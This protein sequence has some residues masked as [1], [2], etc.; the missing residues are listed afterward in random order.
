[1]ITLPTLEATRTISAF[2]LSGN[3][4]AGQTVALKFAVGKSDASLTVRVSPL[5]AG[6][7]AR[8]TAVMAKLVCG[9]N[10]I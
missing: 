9:S 10:A 1:V 3:S 8:A 2:V 5:S 6:T 7:G 4:P